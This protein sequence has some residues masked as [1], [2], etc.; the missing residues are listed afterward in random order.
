MSE[1]INISPI[2]DKDQTNDRPER[3]GF[4]IIGSRAKRQGFQITR[5]GKKAGVHLKKVIAFGAAAHNTLR[6]QTMEPSKDSMGH[7]LTN[8]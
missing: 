3:H 1:P 8:A 2:Q 4:L 6:V 7:S 5:S